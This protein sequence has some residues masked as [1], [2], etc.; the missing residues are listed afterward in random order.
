MKRRIIGSRSRDR[1]QKAL[2]IRGIAARVI[3]GESNRKGTCCGLKGIFQ[4][5]KAARGSDI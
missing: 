4:L 1:T 5:D 3:G 2:E